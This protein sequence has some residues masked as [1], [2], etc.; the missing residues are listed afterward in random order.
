MT[1]SCPAVWKKN[2]PMIGP[3]QSSTHATAGD[4]EEGR[5]KKM[6]CG[7]LREIVD[8]RTTTVAFVTLPTDAPVPPDTTSAAV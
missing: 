6:V 7:L 5:E 4:D 3:F 8:D 1:L 2:P